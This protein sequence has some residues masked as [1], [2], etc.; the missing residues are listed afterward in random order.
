M[1]QK[2]VLACCL[3]IIC[4]ATLLGFS[5]N[6][7][8][9][10]ALSFPVTQ[11]TSSESFKLNTT[12]QA[13]NNTYPVYRIVVP[14]INDAYTKEFSKKFNMAGT[15]KLSDDEWGE[16]VLTDSS[17]NPYERLTFFKQSGGVIWEIPDKKYVTTQTQQ[18]LPSEAEAIK[19][20]N[21]FLTSKG[22]LTPDVKVQNVIVSQKQGTWMGGEDKPSTSIDTILDVRYSRTLNSLP[23]NG[24]GMAV[25]IG[26]NGEIVGYFNNIRIIDPIPYRNVHIITPAQAFDKLKSNDNQMIHFQTNFNEITIDNVSLG[27]YSEPIVYEQKYFIPVYLFSGVAL[28]ED[29]KQNPYQQFVDAVSPDDMSSL[30]T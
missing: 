5:I 6:H 15:E 4:G 22:L 11:G 16:L 28:G 17:K 23:I 24:Q 3:L 14:E 8:P 30:T 10:S 27:Y 18:N 25:N 1:S 7:Q 2:N 20:A 21:S 19:L 12:F 9:V 13:V 29:G 26:K